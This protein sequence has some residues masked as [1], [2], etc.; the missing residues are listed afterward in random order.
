MP[1]SYQTLP[2]EGKGNILGNGV[3]GVVE[4]V[5]RT[6]DNKVSRSRRNMCFAGPRRHRTAESESQIVARKTILFQSSDD[7]KKV[8]RRECDILRRLSHDNII[9][10]LDVRWLDNRV[11]IFMDYCPHGSLQDLINKTQG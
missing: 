10:Q 2:D 1:E 11:E 5:G 9:R 3:F 4:R 7:V 8:A 6:S